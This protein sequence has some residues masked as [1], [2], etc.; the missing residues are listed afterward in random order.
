MVGREEL[1]GMVDVVLVVERGEKMQHHRQCGRP[2]AAP[3]RVDSLQGLFWSA[4]QSHSRHGKRLTTAK[5][6]LAG[7][8]LYLVPG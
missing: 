2:E 5:T 7:V 6:E 1:G 8:T 3:P 4:P